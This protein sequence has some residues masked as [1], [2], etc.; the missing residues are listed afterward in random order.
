MKSK[1]EHRKRFLRRH[2]RAALQK[3]E[4]ESCAVYSGLHVN[5]RNGFHQ[6]YYLI[7]TALGL[8]LSPLKPKTGVTR[9]FFACY[10]HYLASS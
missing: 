6:G 2:E 4:K 1:W 3:E 8:F 5:V 9:T 7:H 10:F